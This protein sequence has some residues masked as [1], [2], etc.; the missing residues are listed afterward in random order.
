MHQDLGKEGIKDKCRDTRIEL[1]NSLVRGM[2][3]LVSQHP[4]SLPHKIK[5]WLKC[6]TSQLAQYDRVG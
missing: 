6:R 5:I 2:G 3:K 4:P 1:C